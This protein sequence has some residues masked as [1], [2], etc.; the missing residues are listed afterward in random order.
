LADSGTQTWTFP[1]EVTQERR[2]FVVVFP[3]VLEATID[4]TTEAEAVA[5]AR[6]IL[7]AVL[8]RCMDEGLPI[9]TPSPAHGRQCISVSAADIKRL[10][11]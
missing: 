10:L 8:G 11:R 9:P 5:R 2:G 7:I 1:L 3:D 4:G 6:Y